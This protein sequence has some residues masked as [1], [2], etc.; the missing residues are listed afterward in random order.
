[1]SSIAGMK[2]GNRNS[3]RY[4]LLSRIPSPKPSNL[5][6]GFCLGLVSAS[7]GSKGTKYSP[8]FECGTWKNWKKQQQVRA[9]VGGFGFRVKDLGLGVRI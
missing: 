8:R 9:K 1:M 4:S 6:R 7:L 3:S 2:L 5:T